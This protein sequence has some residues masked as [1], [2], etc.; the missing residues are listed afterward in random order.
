MMI[1]NRLTGI[2]ICVFFAIALI[3]AALSFSK[4]SFDVI[5]LKPFLSGKTTSSY[6][7][8]F[9]KILFH[10]NASIT[11]WN[12]MGY[13]LFGEGK[14]GVLI[15][16]NGWLFTHEEFMRGDNFSENFETNKSYIQSVS[17]IISDRGVKLIIVPIPSKARIYQENLGRYQFPFYWREQYKNLIMFLSEYNIPVVDLLPVFQNNKAQN[18]F[19]KTDTHWTPMGARLAAMQ[20]EQ[21]I[22]SSL[23][24]ISWEL[25]EYMSEKQEVISYEGDLMR[26]TVNGKSAERFGLTQDRFSPWKTE[27]QNASEGDLFGDSS[28]PVTLVG[29]SYSANKLWHFEG[30]LKEFLGTDILNVADEGLGP[31][32]TME[33][34][35]NSKPFQEMPPKIIIWEMPERYF[36]IQN[37]FI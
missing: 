6:E 24:Y 2:F 23:P 9:D 8:D 22:Q 17:Q 21:K 19:L 13:A 26:Y 36:A 32:E 14:E 37:K 28:L 27:I 34:Y 15:G 1:E 20:V 4:N 33:N 30:F 10:R 3:A 35:L 29:T 16:K 11:L 18:I 5:G 7:K 12:S 31:F 25:K